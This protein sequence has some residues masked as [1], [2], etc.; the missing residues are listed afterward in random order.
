MSNDHSNKE[1]D[2]KIELS[3]TQLSPRDVDPND[4]EIGSPTQTGQTPGHGQRGD[5]KAEEAKLFEEAE[6]FK[7]QQPFPTPNKSV[8]KK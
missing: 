3:P 6:A 4:F 2:Q 5:S 7:P 1:Q 8:T